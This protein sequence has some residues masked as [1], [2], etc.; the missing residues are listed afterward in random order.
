MYEAPSYS[1][2]LAQQTH[3]AVIEMKFSG[4]HGL[5]QSK[6]NI[7]LFPAAFDTNN[8]MDR[9]SK[10]AVKFAQVWRSAL[11]RETQSCEQIPASVT[12]SNFLLTPIWSNSQTRAFIYY[13]SK[14]YWYQILTRMIP[15][16]WFRPPTFSK[17]L[18][19]VVFGAENQQMVEHLFYR[20]LHIFTLLAVAKVTWRSDQAII[21]ADTHFLV[22]KVREIALNLNM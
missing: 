1:M 6:S 14:L 11:S 20:Q 3:E 2:C 13:T 10:L 17:L 4:K 16:N 21:G 9:R 5:Q 19:I 22:K 7:K 15:R 8:C 18:G 12:L